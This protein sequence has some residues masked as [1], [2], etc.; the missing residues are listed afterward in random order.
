MVKFFHDGGDLMWPLLACAIFGI[1]VIFWRLV[2]L[3]RAGASS[4]RVIKALR[5]AI[6]DG[7]IQQAIEICENASG[8]VAVI[9]LAGLRR[10]QRGPES[11]AKAIENSGTL[12]MAFLERGLIWLATI[13]TIA[14]MLGFLGTTLGMV[15]AFNA[16]EVA[17]EVEATLVA[18][19]IKIALITTVTG[20][21][22]AIPM[23]IFY[24]YFVTRIDALIL[25]MEESSAHLLD[26]LE[27]TTGTQTAES[28]VLI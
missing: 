17:G 18:G 9:M 16:I 22:V 23:N 8:P 26:T 14:P 19:G 15:S 12:E 11:V 7:N 2:V 28:G 21:A 13:S 4:K 24:N 5:Q 10:V 27:R 6:S 1:G 3:T 20:L 25:D